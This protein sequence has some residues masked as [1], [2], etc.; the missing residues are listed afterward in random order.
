[1]DYK[2]LDSDSFDAIVTG[3]LTHALIWLEGGLDDLIAEYFVVIK[4]RRYLLMN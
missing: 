4:R 2:K 1:M 3:E